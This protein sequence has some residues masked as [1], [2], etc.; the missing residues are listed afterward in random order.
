[1]KNAVHYS[2]LKQLPIPWVWKSHIF[3]IARPCMDSI[4]EPRPMARSPSGSLGYLDRTEL[5]LKR[6]KVTHQA[7]GT[8][9]HTETPQTHIKGNLHQI[10]VSCITLFPYSKWIVG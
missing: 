9:E 10:Y 4:T 2:E 3:C 8:E 1:M 7:N 5:I 6:T